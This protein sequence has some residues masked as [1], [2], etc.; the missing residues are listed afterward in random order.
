MRR[1][2]AGIIAI[3]GILMLG[4]DSAR[5]MT[6]IAQI[7]MLEAALEAFQMDNGR[8]PTTDEGLSALITAPPAFEK[9]ASYP[10]GGYLRERR[11][12]EDPWGH[13]FQYR[14]PPSHNSDRFDLWSFGADGAPGGTGIDADLGNWPGGSAEHETLQKRQAVLFPLQLGLL[15]GAGLALPIYLFGILSAAFRRRTWRSAL[16]GG[17]FAVL[18]YL[19]VVCTVVS[20]FGMQT[21]E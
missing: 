13:P 7:H 11:V 4:V 3:L 1:R 14:S 21:I 2:T 20:V 12:P 16:V 17:P 10:E 9:S 18:V 8:Y 19:V 5:S 15:V 6:A